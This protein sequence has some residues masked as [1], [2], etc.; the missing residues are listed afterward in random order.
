MRPIITGVCI[1]F[2]A[3]IFLSMYAEY[4]FKYKL[5]FVLIYGIIAPFL[6]AIAILILILA[7]RGERKRSGLD[8]WEQE[9]KKK[10]DD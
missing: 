9:Q 2:F 5:P 8:L 7:N 3:A 10:K 1:G 6:A 4:I